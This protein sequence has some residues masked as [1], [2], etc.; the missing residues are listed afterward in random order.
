MGGL[1]FFLKRSEASSK[2]LNISVM[3]GSSENCP[4]VL[5]V[6]SR[7]GGLSFFLKRSKT[8][9]KALD[10]FRT[11]RLVSN[12]PIRPAYRQYGWREKPQL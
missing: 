3:F 10:Q 6:G 9:S 11:V 5:P 2:A 1:S 4:S 7:M 8:S 12:S